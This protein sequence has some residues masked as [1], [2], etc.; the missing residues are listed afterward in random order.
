MSS[1]HDRNITR[2]SVFF[3]LARGACGQKRQNNSA[4]SLPPALN[5]DLAA[6]IWPGNCS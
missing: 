2:R 3:I 6:A 4:P 5:A 1:Y